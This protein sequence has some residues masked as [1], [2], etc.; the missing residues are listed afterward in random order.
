MNLGIY[1]YFYSVISFEGQEE[2]LQLKTTRCKGQVQNIIRDT[3]CIKYNVLNMEYCICKSALSLA[4]NTHDNIAEH[5][6]N[7]LLKIA[8]S[9]LELLVQSSDSSDLM[10]CSLRHRII[11]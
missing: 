5:E 8:S 3:S 6:K 9:S 1:F 7:L 10:T 11:E 4:Y 2:L